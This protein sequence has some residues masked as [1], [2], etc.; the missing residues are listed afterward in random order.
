MSALPPGVDPTMIR[1]RVYPSGEVIGWTPGVV[2]QPDVDILDANGNFLCRGGLDYYASLCSVFK[3][4]ASPA[5]AEAQQDVT[6]VVVDGTPM[7]VR[8]ARRS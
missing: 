8:G 5:T 3:V 2:E 6:T 7:R 4:P 1:L